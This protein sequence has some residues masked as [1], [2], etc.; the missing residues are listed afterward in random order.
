MA[1]VSVSRPWRF[2]TRFP[3]KARDGAHGA[4][5][6]WQGDQLHRKQESSASREK[7]LNAESPF[8]S[9]EEDRCL[10]QLLVVRTMMNLGMIFSRF[11]VCDHLSAIRHFL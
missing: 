9:F 6:Q 11:E 8:G 1:P 7:R 10:L 3:L 4:V 2:N 5:C